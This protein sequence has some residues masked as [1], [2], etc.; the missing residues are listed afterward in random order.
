MPPETPA[1]LPAPL[2]HMHRAHRNLVH[3]AQLERG[4]VE[5]GGVR[6]EQGQGVV[7]GV[8]AQERDDP[9]RA[10]GELHAE[11]LGIEA[12][13]ALHVGGEEQHVPELARGD[14]PA[15][16]RVA[17]DDLALH[18]AGSVEGHRRLR[19][20]GGGRL[21]ADVDRVAVGIADPDAALGS[22]RG[23]IHLAH[24]GAPQRLA[25]PDEVLARGAVAEMV[26]ALPRA[27]VEQH[28]IAAEPLGTQADRVAPAGAVHEAEVLVEALA[29][30]LVGMA[31]P[32][33][34]RPSPGSR[35]CRGR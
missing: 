25:H 4:V 3:G 21:V 26:E 23:R 28:G 24:A 31:A 1:G 14:A 34:R 6:G 2:G 18:V 16:L 35:A 22:A 20:Y 7:I 33:L 32:P 30:G 10:I 29:D 19:R 5:A 11:R 8:A 13:Q 27:P 9:P 17:A 15:P 12:H